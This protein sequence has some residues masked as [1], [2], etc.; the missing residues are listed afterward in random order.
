MDGI[1]SFKEI[2]A[3]LKKRLLL[4]ILVSIGSGAVSGLYTYY[5]V[6]P[7]Y[8]ASSQFLV[9]KKLVIEGKGQVV[10]VSELD[11]R[12]NLEIINTY[13]VIIRNPVILED[14][15]NKLNLSMSAEQLSGRLQVTSSE[16]SQVVTLTATHT[17]PEIAADIVNT[18]IMIFKE[19]IPQLMQV[20]NVSVLNEAVPNE[21]PIGPNIKVNI[22]I[23]AALG[24][25]LGVGLVLLF[26]FLDTT[27]RS[28]SDLERL[29]INVVG[30]IS[31]IGEKDRLPNTFIESIVERRE[32]HATSKATV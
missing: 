22:G 10:D 8:E 14:V 17:D 31:T 23:A 20:D 4:I 6:S 15:I 27:V 7:L 19:K 25:I 1:K 26:E 29:D 13:S 28:K 24:A 16:E 12:S 5:T 2:I 9:N 30:T 3:A 11:I 32:Q 21:L 18:T